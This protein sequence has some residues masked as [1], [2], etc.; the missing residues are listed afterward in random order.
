ML[1]FSFLSVLFLNRQYES[2][3]NDLHAA[4]KLNSTNAD[5]KKLINKVKDDLLRF[6]SGHAKSLKSRN[7]HAGDVSSVASINSTPLVS[8]K[9]TITKNDLMT[10]FNEK[11]SKGLMNYKFKEETNL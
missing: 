10:D 1:P 8:K 2:A 4:E 7:K 6:H 3:L 9:N 11:T 5:I